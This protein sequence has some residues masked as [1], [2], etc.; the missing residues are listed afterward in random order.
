MNYTRPSQRFSLNEDLV[1]DAEISVAVHSPEILTCRLSLQG[2]LT[3]SGP[4]VDY[5]KNTSN[6]IV[7]ATTSVLTFKLSQISS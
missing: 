1:C 2:R 6:D 4:R 3:M 5:S 7:T